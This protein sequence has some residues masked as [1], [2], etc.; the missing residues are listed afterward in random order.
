MVALLSQAIVPNEAIAVSIADDAT[1]YMFYTSGKVYPP[2]RRLNSAARKRILITGGAGFVGS[3]LTDVLM[4]QGHE[5]T[6]M[7]NF[8]TGARTST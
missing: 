7:D 6:V 5:V 2:V 8:F 1:G 4:R 3:H